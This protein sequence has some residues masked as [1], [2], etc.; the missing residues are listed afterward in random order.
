M[1]ALRTSNNKLHRHNVHSG[2]VAKGDF[3]L[4]SMQ[5]SLVSK[6]CY[7]EMLRSA[8][9]ECPSFQNIQKIRA[10]YSGD[11]AIQMFPLP[12]KGVFSQS[13]SDMDV[14]GDSASSFLAWYYQLQNSI[15]LE[16][17]NRSGAK[18]IEYPSSW[19]NQGLTPD[20]FSTNDAWHMNLE[21]GKFFL[22]SLINRFA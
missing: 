14:Y 16:E 13:D 22:A 18:L 15:V 3:D 19:M 10:Y 5:R 12:T 17:C 9:K 21:F 11:L 7:A 20:Q 8:I 6:N 4:T 2:F 1:P